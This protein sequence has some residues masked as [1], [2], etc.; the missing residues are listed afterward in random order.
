M[1][2]TPLPDSTNASRFTF[3]LSPMVSPMSWK[4][5][6]RGRGSEAHPQ[7]SLAGRQAE[8]QRDVCLSRP[9]IAQAQHILPPPDPLTPRQFQHQLLV[10]RRDRQIIESL[11]ALH[12]R[13]LRS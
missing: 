13:E 9:G 10:H 7:S 4:T 5:I 12:Y 11:Q 2:T 3:S 6:T 1:E 8:S